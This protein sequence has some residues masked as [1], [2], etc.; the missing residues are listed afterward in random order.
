MTMCLPWWIA[1]RACRMPAGGRPVASTITSISG[2][3]IIASASAETW[4]RPVLCASPSEP[5]EIACSP[6]PAVRSWLRARATSR[7]AT[8]TT[9]RPRVT[10]ACARNM[11]PNLPAPIRP[12]VT[13]RPAASRSS[14]MAW[15]FT[16][17]SIVACC[18]LV[19]AIE[20][21]IACGMLLL[22]HR[23]GDENLGR[24]FAGVGRA[25]LEQDLRRAFL[26]GLGVEALA[27]LKSLAAAERD[28]CRRAIGSAVLRRRAALA[29]RHRTRIRQS[30]DRAGRL[31]GGLARPVAELIDLLLRALHV[32]LELGC[33]LFQPA[34]EHVDEAGLEG[35]IGRRRR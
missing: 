24:T 32:G 34:A 20:G 11:V 21:G 18:T 1:R 17:A 29:R 5:A 23:A 31:L 7:S 33:A 4:V 30:D 19:P 9:C 10:R 35:R 12:T 16:E 6:Q 25:A 26:L 27:G 2:K 22:A 14:S 13:G 15:R 28:G 8:P 3:A